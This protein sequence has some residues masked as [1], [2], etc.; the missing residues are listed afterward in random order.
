MCDQYTENKIREKAQTLIDKGEMFT[1]MDI[2][3]A[4]KEAG[5]GT[6]Y[7]E[8]R[9]GMRQLWRSQFFR[10]SNYN[11]T[12]ETMDNGDKPFV[13]HPQ[14]QSSSSYSNRDQSTD[15]KNG[16]IQTTSHGLP[17]FRSP[18][19]GAPSGSSI[20][21]SPPSTSAVDDAVRYAR[22]DLAIEISSK[23]MELVK[24]PYHE[25]AYCTIVNDEIV[26]QGDE[27]PKG[28][29]YHMTVYQL[30]NARVPK[31]MVE[32]YA[33]DLNENISALT[34]FSVRAVNGKLCLKLAHD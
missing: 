15:D 7:R 11:R 20:A 16:S 22:G 10:N 28:K 19:V 31:R 27:P 5:D 1:N 4:L 13:Y 21:T 12:V 3:H 6:V 14:G 18:G 33:E 9:T 30:G 29:G 2:Y 26:I 24:R 8:V 32:R 17:S 34:E 23:L 25:D